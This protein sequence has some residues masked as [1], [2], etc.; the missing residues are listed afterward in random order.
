MGAALTG[1][2]MIL[3]VSTP[4]SPSLS[5]TVRLNTNTSTSDNVGDVKVADEVLLLVK[6]TVFV[7]ATCAH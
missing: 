7:P 3:I 5:V 1:V 4:T 2:T 6:V